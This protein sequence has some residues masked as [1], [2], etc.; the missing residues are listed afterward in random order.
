MELDEPGLKNLKLLSKNREEFKTVQDS[1]RAGPPIFRNAAFQNGRIQK[2]LEE[3][4][5][6]LRESL[7]INIGHNGQKI[8]KS[9]LLCYFDASKASFHTVLLIKSV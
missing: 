3:D 4:G 8:M 5:E 2:I 1:G 6:A 9:M 7:I